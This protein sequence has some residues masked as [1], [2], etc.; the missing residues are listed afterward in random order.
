MIEAWQPCIISMFDLV[1]IRSKASS[2][3]ASKMMLKMHKFAAYKINYELPNHNVGYV[4]NDSVLLLTFSAN[5]ASER[6]KVLLELSQFKKE[7]DLFLNAKTYVI[8]VK[9]QAFPRYDSETSQSDT[10]S[11]ALLLKTSSWAMANCFKIEAMLKQHRADW[12]VDSRVTKNIN[13][14]ARPF[15][16]KKLNLLPK[17]YSR[18]INMY[19]GYF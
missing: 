15:S 8:S 13:S 2:G 4:W 14:F 5:S 6:K 9:G 17:N 12:Y 7:L 10:T 3:E 16:S 1:G 11:K 19:R 18:T